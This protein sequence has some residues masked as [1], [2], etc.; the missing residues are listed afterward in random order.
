VDPRCG[1]GVLAAARGAAVNDLIITA[2]ALWLMFYGMKLCIRI[3]FPNFTYGALFRPLRKLKA[4]KPIGKK[5]WN[6]AYANQKEKRGRSFAWFHLSLIAT[7]VTNVVFFVYGGDLVVVLLM[8]LVAALL[9]KVHSW[10]KSASR[11]RLPGRQRR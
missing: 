1:G 9:W 4:L 7:I 6:Y 3:L 10:I 8:W 11:R 2:I 5:A